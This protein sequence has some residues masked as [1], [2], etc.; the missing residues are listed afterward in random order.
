MNEI[1]IMFMCNI[2]LSLSAN[3]SIIKTNL[4]HPRIHFFLKLFTSI[5]SKLNE[6]VKNFRKSIVIDEK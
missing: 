1:F 4:F 5:T 3:S 2:I 6:S